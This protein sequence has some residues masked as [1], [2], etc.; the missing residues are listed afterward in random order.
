VLTPAIVTAMGVVALGRERRAS[1]LVRALER[2]SPDAFAA[3]IDHVHDAH[4]P[5][6]LVAVHR[7]EACGARSNLDVPL[8]RELPRE[9]RRDARPRSRAPDLEAF[10]ERVRAH[11]EVVYAELGVRGVSLVVDDGVPAC[12]DGGEPLLGAYT[13]AG[14][15]PDLGVEHP[16]EIRLYYRTFVDEARVDR[17]FDVDVEIRE[18]LEHELTHHLHDLAGHDPLDEEERRAIAE[19]AAR[20]VGR[21]ELARRAGRGFVESLAGFARTTWPVWV[22]VALVTIAVALTEAGAR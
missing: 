22:L 12:D 4:Y 8:E 21:R 11:A 14:V 17:S 18:T 15:D 3:V 20:L 19:D 9:P 5:P 2:A 10:E 16:P 13:P 7:C 1:A 6:R